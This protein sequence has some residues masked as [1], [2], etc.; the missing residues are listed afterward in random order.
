MR[1][2]IGIF[3]LCLLV[4]LAYSVQ[5]KALSIA[6]GAKLWYVSWDPFFKDLITEKAFGDSYV[7]STF[8]MGPTLMAGPHIS[9]LFGKVSL[10]G[11]L[12]YGK[13]D[14]YVKSEA[15]Y[16]GET[17]TYKTMVMAMSR[18]DIDLSLA[19]SLLGPLKIFGGYKLQIMSVDQLTIRAQTADNKIIDSLT[20]DDLSN[21]EAYANGPAFGA[22]FSINV[23]DFFLGANASYIY[24]TGIYGP[25]KSLFYGA[26]DDVT[27]SVNESDIFKFE[28]TSNGV[29][30]EPFIGMKAGEKAIMLIGLRYQYLKNRLKMVSEDDEK[31]NF[32]R[33]DNDDPITEKDT[34][35]TFIGASLSISLIF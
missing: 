23:S 8:E 25:M 7:D 29:T 34:E 2:N 9:L 19:Y 21:M 5:L 1:K 6:A 26:G 13:F 22:G 11:A 30:F 32:G 10:A 4:L 12:T 18:T 33:D 20:A 28:I 14:C 24:L 31:Q 35:D 15:D 17:K 27:P 16:G 3:L